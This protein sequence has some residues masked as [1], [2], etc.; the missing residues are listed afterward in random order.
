MDLI[1]EQIKQLVKQELSCSV[2]DMQ[3]VLRV[4]NLS[5]HIAETENVDLD[6]LTAAVLLHDIAHGKEDLD[7]TGTIDHSIL[8]AEMAGQILTELKFPEHKINH[9]QD[10]IISHRYKNNNQPQSLEAKILF[11]ADKLDSLGAIGIARAFAWVGK[12]NA[13]IYS[14][15]NIGDYIADNLNGNLTGKIKNKQNHST[16]LEFETKYKHLADKMY[17]KKGKLI[18]IERTRYFKDYLDRLKR[19]INGEV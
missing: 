7:T 2:H 18:A 11:D 8:G 17:T 13:L 3:H 9:V 15:V 4:Y 14:D 5:L 10:C 6:V 12:F 1:F 19:E 16:N